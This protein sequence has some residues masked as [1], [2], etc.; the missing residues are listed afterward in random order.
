MTNRIRSFWPLVVAVGMTCGSPAT[1]AADPA[2]KPATAEP[3]ESSSV[4][5]PMPGTL[6]W[7]DDPQSKAGISHPADPAP[8]AKATPTPPPHVGF[9]A[10]L[11]SRGAAPA[12]NA[13]TPASTANNTPP[14]RWLEE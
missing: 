3:G 12:P 10:R 4:E 13:S 14:S 11:F 8:T 1:P 2:T 5:L 6:L 9:F 7:A